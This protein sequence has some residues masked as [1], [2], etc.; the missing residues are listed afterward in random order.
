[1]KNRAMLH[2]SLREISRTKTRFLSILG[3]IFLGVAFFVGLGATGP[4]M[5]QTADNY[6]QKYHLSDN[7]IM[8]TL[9]LTKDDLKLVKKSDHVSAAEGLKFTDINLQ[10]KNEIVRVFGY[11]KDQKLNQYRAVKGRL[12]EKSGEI[13]LDNRMNL[14]GEVKIGDDYTISEE[15]DVNDSLKVHQYKVVGFVNTPAYVENVSRGNTNVGTGSIDYFAVVPEENFDTDIYTKILVRYKNLEDQA[16]YSDAY[17]KQLDK[18]QA[19]LEK[20]LKDRP[21]ERLEEIKADAQTEIDKGKKEISDGEKALSD[22]EKTLTD[23]KTKL[24]EGQQ[25]LDTAQAELDNQISA[26]QAEITTNENQ[27][28]ASQNELDAQ[29]NELYTQK[30]NLLANADQIETA[31]QGLATL[32]AK[33]A[34]A[35]AGLQQVQAGLTGISAVVANLAP[36]LELPDEE[37]EAAAPELAAVASGLLAQGQLPAELSGGL[38]AFAANPTKEN[39]SAGLMPLY[40]AVE[41][42][43]SQQNEINAGIAEIDSNIQS[44]QAQINQYE[45]GLAQISAGEAQIAAGQ[46]QIDS[47]FAQINS[48]KAQLEQAQA[49]GQAQ[50]DTSKAE[51]DEGRKTY[52][53]GL[54]EYQKQVAEQ[55]PKLEKAKK[56]ITD[57]EQKLKDLKAEDYIFETRDDNPGY[58]EFEENANRISSLATVFPLIFFLIAALV[59]LTTMTRMVEEKRLEIG[60]FKALGYRN[61]AISMKFLLY[62]AVAGSLGVVFGL[63]L[64]YYLFPMIIFTAY[65]QLYNINAFVTPWY[66]NYSLIGLMVSLVCTV[67]TAFVTLR[68]DLISTPATLM[69]P[70]APKAGQRIFLER[71]KPIWSR[72]NFNQK[73]TMRNLFRY[74]Q[75]MLMTI[76]GIAG[77]MAMIITGFGIRDSISDIVP[78][79]FDKIWHYRGVVTF[80]DNVQEDEL[81]DYYKQVED[82]P[83]YKDNMLISNS[84]LELNKSGGSTQSVTVYVPKKPKKIG[85]F[86]LF[87]ERKTGKKYKLTDSGAIINEKLANLFDLKAGDTFTLTDSEK[88]TYKIK[89]AAVAENYTGH[90]AFMTPDYYQKIFGEE[91]QYNSDFLLFDKEPSSK[92]ETTMA[93]ELMKEDKVINVTFLSHSKDT[94]KDTID[95][96]NLVVWV[97]IISAGL[98][99]FI[100][101]YNLTN[102][103]VSERIRELSTIKVLGFFDNEVTMYVYR[104]N[105]ILTLLGIVLGGFLG[106]IMHAY[107]LQTVEVDLMMFSPDVHAMSYVYSGLITILF[108]IIV[109]FIMYFKL[110]KV[111][112]IEALKS[113]E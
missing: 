19:T 47:G 55:Q 87:N 88:K 73:V 24:D 27:L 103:N 62:A 83:D 51:L 37:F 92:H 93:E 91:P 95:I 8:S 89:I 63:A 58:T 81:T 74:K 57:Q 20:K 35:E 44:I 22:A 23:S 16:A 72:L 67:G 40:A 112:M 45:N 108:S 30:Q 15:D 38:A 42:L 70:K 99:A 113:N 56:E 77:C 52:Q 79:Q 84:T 21:E 50:I 80:E 59:S 29:K 68:I 9:G 61:A 94:L 11:K 111:D 105:I 3:I 33:R 86:I 53:E 75:R 85:D 36:Y 66:W 17:G 46:Q 101:L 7:Q 69:R 41:Q 106:K 43:E 39:L 109:G 5:L 32:Y 98:L 107:V 2:S 64:G 100:V 104:E 48:A 65:G 4:D 13:A 82:L 10:S 76:L 31:R 6:Y 97:L 28:Y 54:A 60:T 26:A 110:K 34:E 12:P 49:E 90:F 78:T 102:I 71:L 1:M 96:L 14:F 25:Q 18:D